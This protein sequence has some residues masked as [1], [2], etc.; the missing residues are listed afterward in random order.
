MSTAKLIKEDYLRH[1]EAVG[2]GMLCELYYSNKNNINISLIENIL[3]DYN[4]H[5][6][7]QR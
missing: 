6:N 7:S 1:G 2:I 5:K 3:K 4:L